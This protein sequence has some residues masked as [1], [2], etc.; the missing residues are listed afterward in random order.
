M[1]TKQMAKRLAELGRGGDTL[2]AHITPEEARV[3][4]ARGGSGTRNPKT[5]LLEFFDDGGSF[6]SAPS[7]TWSP[8]SSG[9]MT[10]PAASDTDSLSWGGSSPAQSEPGFSW[11]NT[12]STPAAGMSPGTGSSSS[13]SGAFQNSPFDSMGPFQSADAF[14]TGEVPGFS[15][16]MLPAPVDRYAEPGPTLSPS[17]VGASNPLMDFFRR[18][19][20]AKAWQ[21]GAKALGVPGMAMSLIGPLK[22]A[23]DAPEGQ[24]FGAF[25]R[26]FAMGQVNSGLN[27][28]TGG[29]YGALNGPQ[30]MASMA[31]VGGPTNSGTSGSSSRYDPMV[32]YARGGAGLIGAYNMARL[33]RGTSSERAAEDQVN[34]LIR[35]PSSVVNLPGFAAGKQAV[36]RAAAGRGYLG[37]G[38]L[39]VALAKYGDQ[40]YNNALTNFNRIAQQNA[41]I[42]QNYNLN[43]TALALQSLGSLGY[44]Y[45]RKNGTFDAPTAYQA[46]ADLMNWEG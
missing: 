36:E 1:K 46:P 24:G 30:A 25:M 22:A 37:S 45:T 35:D 23:W 43:S 32:D 13:F 5:G 41:P 19:G 21:L 39:T 16:D 26:N 40:F 31:S 2:L 12:P 4:K 18:L 33:G 38:N 34:N 20:T 9:G 3:L 7:F 17:D 27:Q 14:Q 11:D 44:A 8:P 10:T 29:M 6:S 15:M 28:A 42:R